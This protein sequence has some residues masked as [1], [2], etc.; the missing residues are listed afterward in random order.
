LEVVGTASGA[1]TSGA[2][3]QFTGELSSDDD[4]GFGAS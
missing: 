1:V 4:G 2:S 3:A